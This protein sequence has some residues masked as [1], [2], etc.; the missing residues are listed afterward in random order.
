MNPILTILNNPVVLFFFWA[1]VTFFT[2]GVF[3][4]LRSPY[5]T[6]DLPQTEF[7]ITL[8]AIFLAGWWVAIIFES[9]TYEFLIG[10]VT[11]IISLSCLF[12]YINMRR[13]QPTRR[14]RS[15]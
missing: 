4:R 6:I 7:L 13:P 8:F 1:A 9:D 12:C 10:G 5:G 2:I 3:R 14:L 15:R 11:A